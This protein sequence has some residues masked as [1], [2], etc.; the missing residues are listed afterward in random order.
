MVKRKIIEIDEERC[1]GCGQCVISCAEGALAIVDGKVKVVNEVFC[2]GLGACIGEC[3]EDALR[4]IEREA[5]EFDEEAVQEHLASQKPE[6]AR[7]VGEELPCGCPSA[8]PI[9]LKAPKASGEAA[10]GEARGRGSEL[11]NWPVQWRLIQ[12]S[13]QFFKNADLVIA[14]DCVPF[15]HADFHRLFLR[16]RPLVVGCPKLDEQGAFLDKLS[17]LFR[18]AAPKSVTVVIME[19]PCCNGLARMVTEAIHRSGRDIPLDTFVVGIDGKV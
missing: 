15:A 1:T 12:P 19:V 5:P 11:V 10:A 17:H 13:A 3:P 7:V 8:A 4:I 18:E 2:D 14:A 6:T 9:L 16:G